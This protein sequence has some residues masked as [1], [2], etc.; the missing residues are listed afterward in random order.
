MTKYKVILY[1]EGINIPFLMLEDQLVR[2]LNAHKKIFR[3]KS[4]RLINDQAASIA[5]DL[6]R[7]L[8]IEYT[9]IGEVDTAEDD[10]PRREQ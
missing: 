4:Y 1:A 10:V 8:V 7:V 5:V 2:L 9:E 3:S 6:N